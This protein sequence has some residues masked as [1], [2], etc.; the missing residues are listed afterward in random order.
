MP[1]VS[2]GMPV[3]NGETHLED[4]LTSLQAQTYRDIEIVVCDNAST[5]RT[6]EICRAHADA[7][8][9]I[10]CVRNA[11]NVG[12]VANFNLA[13]SRARGEYFMWASHDDLWHPTYVTRCLEGFD[14][15]TGLV[16]VGT[17][18]E[19]VAPD[20]RA[21]L[22]V[23]HGLSTLGLGPAA[24]YRSLK[25]ALD[26]GT[27]YGGIFY[28]LYRRSAL[29]RATPLPNMIAGDHV[30][31]ARLS[32]IGSFHTVPEILFTKRW[33]GTSVSYRSMARAIGVT[34]PS[35]IGLPMLWRETSLQAAIREARQL[36][37]LERVGLSVWSWVDFFRRTRLRGIGIRTWLR[38]RRERR[39]QT[40][41]SATPAP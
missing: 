21:R 41:R 26:S 9:R 5:D 6:A 19:L 8:P 25:R 36:S 30:V 16:L 1:R 35:A 23:D 18:A 2:I 17:V 32:L 33:G 22:L 27:H 10:R 29:L 11:E 31:L 39:A 4:A 38:L 13:L 3:F 15:D 37:T 24:R 7:D 12:P 14:V 28:G 20:T 40:R 34:A